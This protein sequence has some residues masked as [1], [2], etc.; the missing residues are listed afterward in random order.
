MRRQEYSLPHKNTRGSGWKYHTYH[1]SQ[2]IVDGNVGARLTVNIPIDITTEKQAKEFC[3]RA[4]KED[5]LI[6]IH[7]MTIGDFAT[8]LFQKEHIR[9]ILPGYTSDET[10]DSFRIYLRYLNEFWNT[11]AVSK[12][13]MDRSSKT[14]GISLDVLT[15]WQ[16]TFGE[17]DIHPISRD[18]ASHVLG[19]IIAV[20]KKNGFLPAEVPY[21]LY[22]YYRKE[23]Y[24]LTFTE[25]EFKEI[26]KLTS[27]AELW[28]NDIKSYSIGVLF[29]I[30]N[31]TGRVERLNRDYTVYIKPNLECLEMYTDDS[32]I[33]FAK[34]SFVC[35]YFIENIL[36]M[37]CRTNDNY[38][39]FSPTPYITTYSN[40]LRKLG[41]TEAEIEDR[42]KYLFYFTHYEE[43]NFDNQNNV[44]KDLLKQQEKFLRKI[45]E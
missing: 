18:P 24:Y 22:S 3:R 2:A 19:Q 9:E 16:K 38:F 21:A 31:F 45:I 37:L 8:Y 44:D 34:H 4:M 20:V 23:K 32:D 42:R 5:L 13:P 39:S 26:F 33:T 40:V 7:Q 10:Q 29:A 27:R 28:G 36:S 14:R 41:Y 15:E 6:P 43:F 11:I 35:I 12:S 25:K 1:V 17:Q 30:T